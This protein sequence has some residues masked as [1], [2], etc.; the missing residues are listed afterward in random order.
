MKACLII[1]RY[2]PS[3]VTVSSAARI[4]GLAIQATLRLP[5]ALDKSCGMLYTANWCKFTNQD[6][7]EKE[8]TTF[9]AM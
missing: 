7:N 1:C 4:S 2:R 8:V 5:K 6:S 9:L 3:T